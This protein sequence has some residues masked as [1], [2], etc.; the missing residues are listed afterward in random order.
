MPLSS[1][2]MVRP[3]GP[4]RDCTRISDTF[5]PC[6]ERVVNQVLEY[7]FEHQIRKH[8]KI[9]EFAPDDDGIGV[10]YRRRIFPGFCHSGSLVPRFW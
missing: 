10:G 3:S 6:P 2:M 9:S 7:F 4:V 8:L 5:P 1:N